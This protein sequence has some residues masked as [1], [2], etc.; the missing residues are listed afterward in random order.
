MR[1][2]IKNFLIN[3]KNIGNSVKLLERIKK[4]EFQSKEANK[5]VTEIEKLF[6]IIAHDLR[7]PFNGFLGLTELLASGYNELTP[8]E[9]SRF[10]HLIHGQAREIFALLENLLDWSKLRLGKRPLSLTNVSLKEIG[11][12]VIGLLQLNADEKQISLRNDVPAEIIIYADV[13][14]VQTVIRNLIS[15]AIKFTNPKGLVAIS[16]ITMD[17]SVSISVTDTG[18][19]IK[20]ENLEKLFDS[21]FYTTKGTKN[22]SGTGLGLRLCQS[23]IKE[24]GGTIFPSSIPGEG[25]TMT[26]TAKLAKPANP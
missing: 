21:E 16:T 3:L 15:N 10:S 6:S 8:V 13:N 25:T 18:I 11:D 17:G 2:M 1:K 4:L 9:Q 14:I 23:L 24:Q 7:A 12:N 22:E 19:G 26:F 5:R 20:P